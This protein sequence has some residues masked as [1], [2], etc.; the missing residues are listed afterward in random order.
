MKHTKDKWEVILAIDSDEYANIACGSQ[1]IVHDI[2]L[3]NARRIVKCVNGYDRLMDALEKY[4]IHGGDCGFRYG[5]Y[6]RHGKCTCGYLQA[7]KEA[8]NEV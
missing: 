4:G 7:L 6:G 2:L 8:D 3:A 5:K 1:Y